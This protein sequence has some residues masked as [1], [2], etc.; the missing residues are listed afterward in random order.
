LEIK[1]LSGGLAFIGAGMREPEYGIDDYKNID[2]KGK[3]VV[4]W[5]GEESFPMA[6]KKKL[7]EEILKKYKSDSSEKWEITMQNA[8]DAGAIGVISLPVPSYPMKSLAGI[9]HNGYTLPRFG[10]LTWNYSNPLLVI[11]ST[12][13][14]Y[15][16]NGEKY[17]PLIKKESYKTLMLGNTI[18]KL[19][20]EYNLSPVN[21]AN[22]VALIEG[23]DPILKNEYITLGAHIDHKGIQDNEVMNGAD[24]NASGC[25]AV[26]EIAEAL[27]KSKPKR[28]VICI[29]FT[30]E[31]LG[32]LG[33]FYFTKNPPVP[34]KKIHAYINLDMISRP[35]GIAN[36]FD[37]IGSDKINPKLKE[38]IYQVNDKTLKLTLD[39]VNYNNFYNRSDQYPFYL[40]RIPAVFFTSGEHKDYHTPAD[41]PEKIDYVFLQKN[42][43]LVYEIMLELANADISFKKIEF[44][45]R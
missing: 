23:S 43:Q 45:N 26:L 3:W 31:E 14:N 12:I 20:K 21:T 40:N 15:L 37:A 6:I 42:C 27:A 24:D 41:D 25:A 4:V 1:E 11:D 36:E 29:L 30:G 2:V 39:S 34:L 28:S 19:Q 13:V 35:D 22:I 8:K 44:I 16:F 17:N 33:S 5:P 7:P 38:T 9:F 18:F 10:Q 32:E